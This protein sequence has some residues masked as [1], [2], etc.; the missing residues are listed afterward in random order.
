MVFQPL[1]MIRKMASRLAGEPVWRG[2]PTDFVLRLDSDG[3]IVSAS[4]TASEMIGAAGAL[5]GRSLLDFVARDDRKSV[6]TALAHAGERKEFADPVDMRVAFT[7]LRVRR[8]PVRVDMAMRAD[9]RGDL[10]VL[11]HQRREKAA[12]GTAEPARTSPSTVPA[13][14]VAVTDGLPAELMADLA[15]EFKTPLNAIMGFADAMRAET[16]G[17]LGRD[18]KSQEKYTEYTDH[19]HASGAHLTSLIG[20]MQSY[21]G[22]RSGKMKIER[23]PVD[24]VSIARESAAMIR[25]A[26]EGAGLAFHFE[27]DDQLPVAMLDARAVRQILI[28]LLSNAVKFTKEGEITLGVSADGDRVNFDVTDTGV[29]MN[30]VVLAKLGGRWSDTHRDGVRGAGGSGLGLSLAFELARLHGGVLT[31]ESNP[32]EGTKARLSMPVDAAVAGPSETAKADIQSQL[33][34]VNAFRAERVVAD[35]KRTGQAA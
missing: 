9:R 17:P 11:I 7:L 8:A 29:G 12:S 33:D 31:I 14:P 19:I 22:A 25:G 26:A 5:R 18:D 35:T 4:Q 24:P 23:E 32:G 16:F 27:T 21:A 1:Q 34:R 2:G 20:A 3:L 13:N 30:K 6:R 28:N 10:T 15:H